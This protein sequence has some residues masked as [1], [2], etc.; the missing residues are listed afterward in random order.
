MG[1]EIGSARRRRCGDIVD[2]ERHEYRRAT[3]V[4]PSGYGGAGPSA[5]PALLDDDSASPASRRLAS[6]DGGAVTPRVG[7]VQSFPRLLQ[8]LEL[9]ARVV[10][11]VDF[12]VS[13]RDLPVFVDEIRDA[14]RVL[15]LRTIGRAV[16][17]AELA[18]RV[19]DQ[20]KRELL[21]RCER[22]ILR[23]RIEADPDDLR[24]L[25]FVLPREAPEPGAFR[26]SATGSGLR[27][28]PEH[29]FLPAKVAEPQ[30]T[31]DLIGRIEIGSGIP[32]LEH[33]R[34]FQ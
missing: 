27:I 14:P 7:L 8:L 23:L 34:T 19:R 9:L 5:S 28:E 6:G 17:E 21:L 30:R 10:L 20:R 32:R 1:A 26:L 15:V 11:R 3:A 29:D 18:I 24:V 22:G 12:R 31:A 25:L 16:S 13:L 4:G 2:D 33:L